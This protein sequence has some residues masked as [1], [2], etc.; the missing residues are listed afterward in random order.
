MVRII[1]SGDVV[2]QRMLVKVYV[3]QLSVDPDECSI[4]GVMIDPIAQL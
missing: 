4:S 3:K 1:E 2:E